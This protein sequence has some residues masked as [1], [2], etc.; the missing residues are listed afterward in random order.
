[1]PSL[2]DPRDPTRPRSHDEQRVRCS[3]D[4]PRLINGLMPFSAGR[5]EASLLSHSV[6]AAKRRKHTIFQRQQAVLSV[7]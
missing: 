6:E 3:V 2:A 5:H 4:N 1:M 7:S